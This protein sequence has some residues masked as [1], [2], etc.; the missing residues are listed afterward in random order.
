MEG[1]F[2]PGKILVEILVFSES[3]LSGNDFQTITL[4]AGDFMGVCTP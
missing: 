2:W 4:Q 3:N 1:E